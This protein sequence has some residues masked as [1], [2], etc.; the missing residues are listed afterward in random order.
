MAARIL[1]IEDN[2][3][4]LALMTYLLQAFGHTVFTAMD[5]EA[6]IVTAD[7]E[8]PDLIICDVH[9]PK[10]DGY[11]VARWLKCHTLLATIPLVAVTALAMVGDR[12]KVLAAGF[13][14]YLSKPIVPESFVQEVEAF[15]SPHHSGARPALC[16]FSQSQ[17]APSRKE[18]GKTILVVDDLWV[19]LNLIR[20]ILEP[21]GYCVLTTFTL[22]EA[23]M[24]A[25]QEPPALIV[26]D[27]NIPPRNGYDF[28]KV[29]KADPQLQSIPLIIISSSKVPDC[30]IALV[31]EL[32][33][34]K[35]FERPITPE[36][37]L[38]EITSSLEES[39]QDHTA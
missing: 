31:R 19:N 7:R 20:S 29:I 1:I 3:A 17:Q 24:Q 13:D 4:N 38:K 22:A 35:F 10:I 39:L 27:W 30:D 18:A 33:A 2:Q 15:L 23:L 9:L 32:G 34:V 12:D 26:S 8:R 37:L 14:G 28:I 21:F 5:G 36:Q 6:G 16:S 11:E 25:R